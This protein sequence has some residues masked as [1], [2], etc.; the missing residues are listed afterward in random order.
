MALSHMNDYD[1]GDTSHHLE[2]MKTMTWLAYKT[3]TFIRKIMD[4]MMDDYKAWT[5]TDDAGA[6][7]VP[8]GA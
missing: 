6:D 7:P 5:T 2:L 3:V 8:T 4:H 1:D